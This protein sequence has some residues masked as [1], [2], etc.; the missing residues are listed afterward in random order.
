[1]AAVEN[2][3]IPKLEN[4]LK[5]WYNLERKRDKHTLET[6]PVIQAKGMFKND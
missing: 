6:A 4:D 2:V 3:E 5:L 1:M